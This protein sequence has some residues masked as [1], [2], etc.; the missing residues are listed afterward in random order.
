M[1]EESM[2][3]TL[4]AYRNQVKLGNGENALLRSLATD[5]REALIRF[6]GEVPP[7]EMALMRDPVDDPRLIRAWVDNLDYCAVF[8]LV[9]V[10]QEHRIVGD[11]TLHFR[12]GSYRH[13]AEVRMYISTDYRGLGLGHAMLHS[14]T[15]ISRGLGLL[16]LIAH[17]VATQGGMMRAFRALGFE[18]CAT[19]DDFFMAPS[20][21]KH[22]VALLTLSLETRKGEDY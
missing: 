8:P 20:G 15:N 4:S 2:C 17:V 13:V 7:A 9:A 6:F 18:H 16:I 21:E 10:T 19:L 12:R 14:L 11:A 5:D 22:D 3:E 1:F